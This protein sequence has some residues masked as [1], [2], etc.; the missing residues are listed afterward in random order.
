MLHSISARLI[1]AFIALQ[2]WLAIGWTIYDYGTSHG[3]MTGIVLVFKLYT[4]IATMLMA[5]TFTAIAVQFR[6]VGRPAVLAKMVVVA[7]ILLGIFWTFKGGSEIANAPVRGKIAHALAPLE[8]I[9]YWIAFGT[10]Y[11]LKWHHT[12]LWTI[13][14]LGY[15]VAV[16]GYGKLTGSYVYEFAN[17]DRYGLHRVLGIVGFTIIG[18]LALGVAMVAATRIIHRFQEEGRLPLETAR[19]ESQRSAGC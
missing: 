18:S 12:L 5:V 7:A 3:F 17:I 8:V 11:R 14:P 19:P 4:H 6:A 9:L 1:A 15:T 10:R 13:F 2:C 16:L